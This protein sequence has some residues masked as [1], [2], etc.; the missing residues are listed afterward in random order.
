MPDDT[1]LPFDVSKILAEFPDA[2]GDDAMDNTPKIFVVYA[3]HDPRSGY[4]PANEVTIT[5]A[6]GEWLDPG[7]SAFVDVVSGKI[8]A[9]L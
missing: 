2:A 6:E 5:L 9:R 1:P 4:D 7:E 3:E 8:L